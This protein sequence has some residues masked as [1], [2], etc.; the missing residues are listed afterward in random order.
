M[1]DD[2]LL[3]AINAFFLSKLAVGAQMLF[4]IFPED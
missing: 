3:F 4:Q 2:H 1:D